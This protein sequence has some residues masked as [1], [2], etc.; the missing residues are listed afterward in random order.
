MGPATAISACLPGAESPQPAAA[1]TGLADLPGVD[2]RTVLVVDLDGTLLRSDLLHEC[3]W[4]ALARDWSTPFRAAGWVL[5]GRAALKQRLAARAALDPAT[6]P[7][8]PGLLALI[9]SWRAAGRV[10]VLATA[11]DAA[12]AE[13]VAAHLGCFDHVIGSD[14]RRNLKGA[15]KAAVL[16]ERFGPQGFVYAG[17]SRADLPVWR[18]SRAAVTVGAPPGLARD[19]AALGVP[20]LALPMRFPGDPS[21]QEAR[22]PPL[23]QVLRAMRPHQ[24]LK[25]LLCFFPMLADQAFTADTA[26]RSFLAFLAFSLVA[27]AVYVLNDLVDLAADR[28][29]P[30]KRARPFASGR[31]PLV[32]GFWLLPALLAAGGLI[33]AALGPAFAVVLAVYLVST[34]AYSLALKRR[35]IADICVLAGLYSLRI[36]AGAAAADIAPSVWLLAFSIFFFLSLAAVK[37]L[38]E[39]V[40]AAERGT[41]MPAGRG[42]RTGDRGL[43][44]QMAI[45]AGYVAVLVLALYL[46]TAEVQ[47]RFGTPEILW[48]VCLVLLYW[49][50]RTVMIAHRGRMQDDPVVFAATDRI[51]QISAVLIVGLAVAAVSL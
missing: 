19:V 9:R 49:I 51:S 6:L 38:A 34:T 5:A 48:G 33:A 24:W 12:L 45:A 7:Y 28:A 29:H 8:D 43:V 23:P 21:E 18:L 11:S 14:G 1:P 42:Y 47:A 16:Q 2:D 46:D 50:S 35:I 10:T 41:E 31:L 27:S 36:V 30:R 17:D 44:G 26:L 32:H 13:A 22:V 37:R 25:N 15:E 20:V 4:S 3:F 39:L 40:D